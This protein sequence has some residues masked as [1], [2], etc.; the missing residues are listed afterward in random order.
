M[1]GKTILLAFIATF[2]SAMQLEAKLWNNMNNF[3]Q[4]STS[5]SPT[6]EQASVLYDLYNEARVG[7][8]H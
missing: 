1:I 4:V 8:E 3:A 2:T 5:N 6:D 7:V